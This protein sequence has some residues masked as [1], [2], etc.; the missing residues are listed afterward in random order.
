MDWITLALA[1]GAAVLATVAQLVSGFGFNLLFVPLLLLL[2]IAP[3]D[4]VVLSNL[5]GAIVTSVLWARERRHVDVR[6][7][8]GL[9]AGGLAGLP[10]G[11]MI[12]QALSPPALTRMIVVVVLASLAVVTSGLRLRRGLVVT[13]SAGVVAGALATSTGMN[14]PPMV[15]A[16]RAM[17][18]DERQYRATLAVALCV[19][20]WA[21]FALFAVTGKV[22]RAGMPMLVAAVAAMPIGFMIGE[23]L[24]AR[25]DARRMR[26][27]IIGLMLV[28]LATVLV[29]G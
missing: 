24:F 13:G 16:L 9:L 21:G 18:Y 15:A 4:A 28:S 29:R 10:L 19:Q 7:V 3:V 12:A 26:L 27:W 11:L 17:P 23:R 6:G 1:A 25:I 2:R 8:S 20:S 22:D 5:C 14:G